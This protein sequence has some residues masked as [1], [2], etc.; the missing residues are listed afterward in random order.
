MR[1][2]PTYAPLELR[3]ARFLIK[4]VKAQVINQPK[5][6]RRLM[7]DRLVVGQ[8]ILAPLTLVRVQVSQ[9]IYKVCI[10]RLARAGKSEIKKIWYS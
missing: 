5:P 2:R 6:W 3:R 1:D 8:R 4:D 9:P 10:S 7:R